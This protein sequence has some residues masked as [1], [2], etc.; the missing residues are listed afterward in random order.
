MTSADKFGQLKEE[1]GKGTS[2]KFSCPVCAEPCDA[3]SGDL[4]KTC[5]QYVHV[6]CQVCT[7]K[8][9]NFVLYGWKRWFSCPVC[10]TQ[11][12]IERT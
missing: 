6:G 7:K 9:E 12:R 5:E 1:G 4:C 3:G 10:E 11:I 8:K 2:R